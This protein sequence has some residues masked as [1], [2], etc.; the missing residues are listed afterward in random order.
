MAGRASQVMMAALLARFL[1][2]DAN[3]A[4]R[5]AP[6]RDVALKNWNGILVGEVRP[7]GPLA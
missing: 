6:L 4:A 5:L 2:M 1:P 3:E 7:A